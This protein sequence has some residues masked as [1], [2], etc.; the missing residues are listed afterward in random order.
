MFGKNPAEK[1][2]GL[3][4]CQNATARRALFGVSGCAK[5]ILDCRGFFLISA[6]ITRDYARGT[7]LCVS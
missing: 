7:Y 1:K 4:V 5:A 6:I 3:C 2:V